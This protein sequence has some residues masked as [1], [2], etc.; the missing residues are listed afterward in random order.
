MIRKGLIYL[1]ITAFIFGTFLLALNPEQAMAFNWPWDQGHDCVNTVNPDGTYGRYDYDGVFQGSYSSKECCEILC[2]ICPVYANTG[3]LQ[4]IFTDLTALGV[5]PALSITRTYNSQN[6]STSLLGHSWTFNFGRR[7]II[8]RKK[9]GEKVIGV[10]QETG[11]KN[12][13]TEDAEGNLTLLADYGVTYTLTKNDDSTYTIKELDGTVYELNADGKIS[14]IVDK[15]DNA[16]TFTYDIVGCL[17]R[18]TNASDNYVDIQLGPNGKIASISD[19][20]GRTVNYSY[21][22]N[23]DLI[24]AQDPVG[25]TTQ[26]TYDNKHRLTQIIDPRGNTILSATYDTDNKV[27]T[28]MEKGETY[29]ISYYDGYTEKKD[30]AG[31]TWT[32]YFNDIGIIEKVVDPLGNVTQQHNNKVTATSVDWEEDGNGNRTTYTHDEN[33]NIISE[34]DPLGNPYTYTYIPE[35]NLMLTETDPLGT[36]TK[37]EYDSSGNMTKRIRDFGGPLENITIYTYD[38]E[39]DMLGE[40]DH[41]GKTIT[42]EYD[43][44][45]NITKVIDPI[46]NTT[47]YMYDA[48]GNKISEIDPLGN[49]TNFEYDLIGRK[50]KITTPL[51]NSKNYSFDVTGNLISITDFRGNNYTM[52]YDQFNRKIKTTDALGNVWSTVYIS[53]NLEK[54]VDPCGRLTFNYYDI[55]DRVIKSIQKAGDSN[56]TDDADDLVWLYTYDAVGNILTEIDSLGNTT[57]YT[58]NANNQIVSITNPE[59]ETASYVYN[60]DSSLKS[61]IYPN[62]NIVQYEYDSLGR[63]IKEYDNLGT[64]STLTYN[65]LSQVINITDGNNN[66]TQFSYDAAGNMIK[67]TDPLG[68]DTLYTFDF[69]G[70]FTSMTDRDGHITLFSY[71]ENNQLIMVTD[72]LGNTKE[73]TYD[74]NGNQISIKDAN[75]NI[76]TYMFDELNRLIKRTYADNTTEEFTYDC[77]G[78]LETVKNQKGHITSYEYDELYRRTKIDFPG[79]NDSTFAYDKLNRVL[80]A[81]N[82]DV[83]ITFTYDKV[84]RIKS[85]N[86][87]GY[88]TAF[89]YDVANSSKTIT[90][91]SGRV[92]KELY[93]ARERPAAIQDG[94]NADIVTYTYDNGDLIS[95]KNV[96]NIFSVNYTYN[97]NEWLTNLVYEKGAFNVLDFEYGFNKEGNRTYRKSNH[98]LNKSERYQ[99]DGLSRLNDFKR[100]ILASDYTIPSPNKNNS[101]VYDGADNRLSMTKNG[102]SF[103]YTSN[104]TNG[105]TS[106][107]GISYSYDLSGNLLDDNQMIYTYGPSNELLTIA[108]KATGNLIVD[109][110]YDAFERRFKKTVGSTTTTEYIFEGE[111]SEVL[112][113]IQNGIIVAEYVYGAG[114]NEF[115]L[116]SKNGT[117][118]FYQTDVLGS[119]INVTDSNGDIVESYCYDSFGETTIYNPAGNQISQTAIDNSICYIGQRY[120]PETGLYEFHARLYDPQ[121]GRFLRYDPIGYSDGLNLYQYAGNDPINNYD[122]SGLIKAVVSVNLKVE[123][124]PGSLVLLGAFV[125]GLVEAKKSISLDSRNTGRECCRD[126]TIVTKGE[127]ME[128]EFS[129]KQLTLMVTSPIW[130]DKEDF[131]KD[132]S[133]NVYWV[134]CDKNAVRRVGRLPR[135]RQVTKPAGPGWRRI[136]Y[137]IVLKHESTHAKPQ[138]IERIVNYFKNIASD[139]KT[140]CPANTSKAKKEIEDWKKSL[141][142][143]YGK[144]DLIRQ[145]L[146]D[147]YNLNPD[148]YE[149]RA[150]DVSCGF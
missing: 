93:D 28:F 46:G 7:L 126:G 22:Q 5:G 83:T 143:K 145:I 104:V 81:Q 117:D 110:K 148:T 39:G 48:M 92:I 147:A 140:W 24:S 106:V 125:S 44:L 67:E 1:S 19:I 25:N 101:F 95:T 10:L 134:Q 21:D 66:T 133:G 139:K 131:K 4:K 68:N 129:I 137:S 149:S 52:E 45:G 79:T 132:A 50:T 33:G 29:T 122:P 89:N 114:L 61:I 72:A 135:K 57:T 56:P 113:D 43:S 123:Q 26:Y 109:Y 116:A 71:N 32:Y 112:A 136:T 54:I 37:Y 20:L 6:L 30:S 85:T 78:N 12:F 128:K 82:T 3:R 144:N 88:T 38:S 31:N 97:N 127:A 115:I 64:I 16:L 62:G 120:Q 40:T 70:N 41:I 102:I 150:D 91:P 146:K 105:Y 11:E 90:Y 17:T 36:T 96:N 77:F 107:N 59:G 27:S 119:T 75:G 141:E 121:N 47:Q 118:Y 124:K 80:I 100:G 74:E 8:T 35:T 15:N 9:T 18:I 65:E 76:T 55:Y 84:G 86:Q 87:S 49:Q 111:S 42:Y 13:F 103:P 94:Q 53:N 142:D 2:K 51:G 14:R 60:Y 69:E 108:D 34:T 99:Y 138:V 23:G 98:D 63:M 73:Y 130:M 58:Y